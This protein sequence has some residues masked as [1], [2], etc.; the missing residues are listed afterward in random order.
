ML[1]LELEL[2]LFF[3]FFAAFNCIFY[4]VPGDSVYYPTSELT[5]N[6]QCAGGF[7][8]SKYFHTLWSVALLVARRTNNRKVIVGSIPTNAVCIGNRLG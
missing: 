4:K 7:R 6:K 2:M 8:C 5:L 3:V 1:E